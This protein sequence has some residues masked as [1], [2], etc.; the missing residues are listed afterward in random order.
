MALYLLHFDRPFKHVKHYLG[1]ARDLPTM[2]RRIDAHYSATAGDG[3]NHRLMVALREAGISFTLAR[4]WPE[5]T[6]VDER[7]KKQRGHARQCPL[8]R[9]ERKAVR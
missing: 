8:C 6:R 7:R 4:V 9:D 2:H 3:K 1:F 5:G